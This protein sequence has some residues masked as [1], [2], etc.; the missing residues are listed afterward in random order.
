MAAPYRTVSADESEALLALVAGDVSRADEHHRQRLLLV[1]LAFASVVALLVGGLAGMVITS[2]A[3]APPA[4][5]WK[6]HTVLPVL[7][8]RVHGIRAELAYA[9]AARA[10]APPRTGVIPLPP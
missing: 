8:A 6:D 4:R 1:G 9:R 5:A 3:Y 10:Q 7:H 2:R